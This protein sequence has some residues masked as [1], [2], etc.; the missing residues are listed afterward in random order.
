MKT[1]SDPNSISQLL[2][3][4]GIDLSKIE[5]EIFT[6]KEI[7]ILD[8]SL[9]VVKS[10]GDKNQKF[11]KFNEIEINEFLNGKRTIIFSLFP[12]SREDINEIVNE[13]F[14]MF[15]IDSSQRR[16]FLPYE[17]VIFEKETFSPNSTRQWIDFIDYQVDLKGYLDTEIITLTLLEK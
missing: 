7:T 11:W 8:K 4:C 3:K 2:L 12:A 9:G 16:K 1:S 15:G 17:L 14:K 5:P 6:T 13:L 10:Y